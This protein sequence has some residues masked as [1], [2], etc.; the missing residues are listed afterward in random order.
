MPAPRICTLFRVLFTVLLAPALFAS[1]ESASAAPAPAP[2]PAPAKTSYLLSIE[3]GSNLLP[4]GS[5]DHAGYLGLF[6]MASRPM[7]TDWR[8]AVLQP[9]N[10]DLTGQRELSVFDT[11]V[12]AQ[13]RSHTL[14]PWM[15]L[16]P[17][18][19]LV[20]PTS[21]RSRLEDS[22][23][24][25]ARGVLRLS[26]DLTS[27]PQ[28]SWLGGFLDLS[29][30]KAFHQYETRISG[31]VNQEYRFSGWLNLS[32]SLGDR[33][34]LSTDLIRSANLSYQGA[35]RNRFSITETL[36]YQLK[37]GRSVSLGHTN[38]GDVLRANGLDS[39]IAIYGAY[40]SRAFVSLALPF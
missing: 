11:T 4:W 22:L 32:A 16:T 34:Q 29:A 3:A 13:H 14:G 27:R 39:N 31:G 38:E 28:L 7:G 35:I 5:T 23:Y 19:G 37:S 20:L 10:L 33:W 6:G 9:A 24:L 26:L 17:S 2:A 1:A 30:T 40:S 12:L 18:L 36:T 25:G 15:R 21:R 8:L